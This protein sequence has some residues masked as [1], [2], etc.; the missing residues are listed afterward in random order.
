VTQVPSDTPTMATAGLGH[1]PEPQP[2]PWPG[3]GSQESRELTRRRSWRSLALAGG[4]YLVLSLVVWWNVWS[5]PTSTTTCGCGDSA[6]FLWFFAWPAHALAHGL[7]PWWSSAMSTPGGVNLL[8]NTSELGLAVPLAPV[9]WIWGPVASMN[10]ALTL[11]PALSGLAAFVL[12]RR[13][14]SWL[15]AAFVGGLLY[16]FSPLVLVSLTDAHLMLGWAMV[17]PLV[18]ACIDELLF[19]RGWAFRRRGPAEIGMVL[20]LL[21]IF[22]FFVGTEVLVLWGIAAAIGAV[23]LVAYGLVVHGRRLG[24]VLQP[25]VRRVATGLGVTA[26]LAGLALAYPT[27]FALAGPAHTSGRVWPTLELG[28]EGTTVH[29][30]LWPAP[31]SAGFTLFTHRVGGYQGPTLSG[32][33]VGVALLVVA[34]LGVVACR[35]NRRV[36]LFGSLAVVGGV[37]SLGERKDLWLP[38]QVLARRPLLENII[39][40]RFVLVV[41]LALAVILAIAV[42]QTR[43][44]VLE[45][46]SGDPG[47]PSASYPS[48]SR[49]SRSSRVLATSLAVIVG[50]IALV[51]IGTYLARSIPTT[52]QQVRSPTWVTRVA[53]GLPAHHVVLMLPVPYQVIESAMAWQSVAGFPY[54]MAGGGGPGGVVQRAGSYQAGAEAIGQASFSF[55]GQVVRP[56]DVVAARRALEGWKVD[57]VVLPDEAGLAAYDQV[58]SVPFAVAFFTAATGEAPVRQA[59][60]WVWTG[61]AHAPP[62][63]L[64]PTE[65]AARCLPIDMPTRPAVTAGVAG[66][67]LSLSGRTGSAQR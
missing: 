31:V 64:A 28:Y 5:A 14:V 4:A 21:C 41:Y 45:R 47:P 35:R 36:L 6:L 39:P 27:W 12:L 56:A 25:H 26:A 29:D 57:E 65:A 30:F 19:P 7:D 49:S 54:L 3:P 63:I 60:A 37:L 44:V 67:I 34:A 22:Q 52:S 13:W 58:T 1:S 24:A 53:P 46:L 18:I 16:G 51:P 38:W 33:Y 55:T 62:T 59:G 32:Q 40:S 61:L 66:C 9:T 2:E 23:F 17:P 20:G 8:A 10:V 42:D 50:A 11:A 15:P 48:T 43:H